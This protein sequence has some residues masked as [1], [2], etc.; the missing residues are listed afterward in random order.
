[1]GTATLD[2]TITMITI[3]C[4]HKGCGIT[5]AVPEWWKTKRREDKTWWY[6]PNGH[7]QHFPGK[8]ETEKLR[9]QLDQARSSKDYWVGRTEQERERVRCEERSHAATK[10]HFTRAKNRIANGVC[11]CCKRT[12][13][14]VQ[15][16]MKS[17]HPEY[18]AGGEGG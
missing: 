12:F 15:R 7:S 16:H 10:G 1:M 8:S 13:K 6:C 18:A 14:N 4:C 9:A 3:T 5:F 2:F 11:P 17:K